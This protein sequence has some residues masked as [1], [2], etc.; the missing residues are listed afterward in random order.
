MQAEKTMITPHLDIYLS[1]APVPYPEAMVAMDA[2]VAAIANGTAT[3][4]VWILE[5]P[6]LYTMGTSA[7]RHDLLSQDLP[8]YASGRGGQVTY[9]GPGQ[10]VAYVMLNLNNP[11]YQRDIRTHI[12]RLETWGQAVFQ[13]LNI[14]TVTRDDRIGLWVTREDA[15]KSGLSQP[16]L[17]EEK[18]AAIGVR[19]RKWISFHGIALNIMPNLGHF[20]GI[21]PCGIRDYGVTSVQ[22]LGSITSMSRAC[23]IMIETLS[24]SFGIKQKNI[25][26]DATLAQV[27][28]SD[29]N[30]PNTKTA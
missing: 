6:A 27:S 2:R 3:N 20:D 28:G 8:C 26:R 12:Q 14:P 17:S 5:H 13:S 1:D 23:D 21:V 22:K 9:H 4:A 10:W 19:V 30:H 18:I 11:A 25:V 15:L 29:Y 16:P 24:Q 7:Q